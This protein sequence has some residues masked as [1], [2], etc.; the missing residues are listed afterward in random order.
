MK[1]FT[2]RVLAVRN[3][4]MYAV[5]GSGNS[6]MSDSWM[7]WKPRIEEPS[8]FSPSSKTAWSND[9]TGT[10]KC[11]IT[12]GRSQN[13]TSTIST[14]SSLTYLRSSSLFWNI[15]PPWL[16]SAGQ[17]A[18]SA[19][20]GPGRR[21]LEPARNLRRGSY[22]TVSGLFRPC[23][24]WPSPWASG[25]AVYAGLRDWPGPRDCLLRDRLLGPAHPRPVR[26]LVRLHPRRVPVH[27]GLRG[28][29]P[30]RP[31][32]GAAGLRRRDRGADGPLGRL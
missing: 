11:C 15:R 10:V 19:K 12:P 14:P 6:D 18:K 13:R 9:E 29:E 28:A 24:R 27:P 3:G 4:S 21:C 22:L 23:N 1:K 7:A 16:P 25:P 8:K 26:G 32:V 17:P 31:V 20:W 5:V 30:G 2:T